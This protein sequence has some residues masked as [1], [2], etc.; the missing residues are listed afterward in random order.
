MIE[1]SAQE[2]RLLVKPSQR[3]QEYPLEALGNILGQAAKSIAE[4]IQCPSSIA[5]QSI[6]AAASLA[7]QR[8][9]DVSI[10]GRVYPISVFCLTVAGSGDRK[11]AADSFAL[12]AHKAFEKRSIHKYQK[13]REQHNNA[14]LAFET[15][16]LA[17]QRDKNLKL[18]DRTHKLNNLNVPI[19]PKNPQIIVQEPTLEGLHKSFEFGHAYQ[20]LFNDE[21]GQFLGG[22][23]M[24]ADNRQKT[25][26]G[27]SKLWDGSE[28]VRT[29]GTNNENS[30]LF[31]KRLSIHLMIQPVIAESTFN[32]SL[33][34]GQGFLPRFLISNSTSIAG[35][36]FYNGKNCS[37]DP[38]LQ[39]YWTTMEH[40]LNYPSPIK[41][42]DDPLPCMT[43]SPEAKQLWIEAYNEI[44]S[45]LGKGG[46][47]SDIKS[48]ASKAAENILRISSILA[49]V[50]NIESMTV[51]SIHISNATQLIRYYLSEVNQIHKNSESDLLIEQ[52]IILLS[53][54]QDSRALVPI[55]RSDISK[56]GPR[57]SGARGSVNK[58]QKLIDVLVQHGWLTPLPEGTIVNGSTPKQA[59]QLVKS[60]E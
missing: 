32:D 38:S 1:V 10:D 46:F 9:R 6:L 42:D 56:S 44:E 16:K 8:F 37:N 59:Y 53:W 60:S 3:E 12:Q 21:G 26:T 43:L 18:E 39:Q 40:I 2:P 36:R 52:A 31:G 57:P 47:Y 55:T 13:V 51:Q 5:G 58:A 25:I 27:I 15:E 54:L 14:M 22:H 35:T 24:S 34:D 50:D 29:R 4:N 30:V 48:S 7:T 45:A 33:L 28:I 49:L 19:E 20:G 41:N 17:I 11:S 23:A